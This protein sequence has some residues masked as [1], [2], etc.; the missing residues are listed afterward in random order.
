MA[1]IS[2]FTTFFVKMNR[3]MDFTIKAFY[4]TMFSIG[5]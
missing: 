3:V 4:R 1:G 5:S 2:L